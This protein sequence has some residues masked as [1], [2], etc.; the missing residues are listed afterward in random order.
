MV[1]FAAMCR[2][3]ST[4]GMAVEGGEKRGKVPAYSRSFSS[5]LR[6]LPVGY[7]ATLLVSQG[8]ALPSMQATEVEGERRGREGEGEWGMR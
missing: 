2:S 1:P 5:Q 7:R 4:R 3:S 6:L 8:E